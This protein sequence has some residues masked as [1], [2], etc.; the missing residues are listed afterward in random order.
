MKHIQKEELFFSRFRLSDQLFD[1]DSIFFDI[2]TTGFSPAHSSIYL[3]GCAYRKEDKLHVDQFFA[4]DPDQE[5]EILYSFSELLKG[6]QTIITYNGVGFD[7]PFL[8]AKY[9][10]FGMPEHFKD[11]HYIDI[12]KS[13]S[14]I[15]FL[16]KL[17]NYKQ[18]TLENFLGL[19]R[20][21]RYSGGEL[22][23]VYHEYTASKNG[24]QEDLLLLHNYEDIVGM[25]QLLPV[26][27]YTEFFQ[28]QY[29][30]RETRLEGYRA[31]DG[32]DK[33][34]LMIFLENDF[35][36]PQPISYHYKEFYLL[37]KDASTTI[38]VPVFSGELLFFYDNYKDYYYLPKEDMAVHKSIASF[39]DRDFRENAKASNCYTHK[40]GDFL[41][42]YTKVMCPAF[43]KKY[44]DPISYFELSDDFCASDIML[45]RYVTH[46]LHQMC[47]PDKKR[48]GTP[49]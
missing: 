6:F 33:K 20:D 31:P 44:K 48:K 29:T 13:V 37:M 49:A 16:L 11:F 45:R 14:E 36:V 24:Y 10:M 39:V 2:E 3:I 1:A 27:A 17:P 42:Q 46:I 30:I 15:K 47:T 35:A 32:S 34:E 43:Y 41:P 8:K 38:R 12:Y 19:Q 25:T 9:D 4:E 23:N 7:I 28:G 21:D 40:S 26:F 22:I 18:K 5:A